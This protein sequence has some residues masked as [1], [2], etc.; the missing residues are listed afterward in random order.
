[1][2]R[3]AIIGAGLAGL[4]AAHRLTR[5]RHS[6]L[7]LEREPRLGGQI[8][9]ERSQG[10]VVELGAEGYVA[11]SEAMLKLARELGI[12]AE[13]VG[14]THTQ[15][16]GFRGGQ[17]QVLAP[18]ES[19][20]LLG[21][22]V[23]KADLGVGIRS[24]RGGMSA[25]I[26]SFEQTLASSVEM[27]TN[28]RV[29]HLERRARGFEIRIQDGGSVT[30]DRVIVA[31]GAK[32]ASPLLAPMIGPAASDLA[33]V[34]ALSNV[35]VSLAFAREAIPHALDATG[36]VVAT[37]EQIHGA[38]A[39]VFASSKFAGRA[40]DGRVNLRV[41]FRPDPREIKTLSDAAYVSR[42][43]EVIERVLGPIGPADASWVARWPDALPVFDEPSKEYVAA[44]EATLKGSGITLAG[45]GF[46][47]VG[48][49]GALRSGLSV[50]QRL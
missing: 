39:C 11:R 35:N 1:M 40:P 32:A 18:G 36:F 17:L 33:K 50:D 42:A 24:L 49:D 25:L 37:D 28:V 2:A 46:H 22:Q 30:A 21:F 4:C 9:T 14:Q 13:L 23:A 41:F 20:S 7:V 45:S 6:V 5:L 29:Q 19:A 34:T 44:L 3:V 31:T 8:H 38:R 47:G 26:S 43:R 15:S 12:E 27:R 48:I 10:Y 16:L